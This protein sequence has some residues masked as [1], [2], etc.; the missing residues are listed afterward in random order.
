MQPRIQ[1]Q[2]VEPLVDC[3]RYP[4]KR[5]VGERIEVY[6]TVFKDGHDTLAGAIRVWEPGQRRPREEPL[7]PLGN[8]RW[9][10][11]FVADKPGRWTYAVVAWTDRIATWQ[12]ELRRKVEAGQEDLNG[13][14]SEGAVL[15]GRDELTVEQGLAAEAGDRHGEA[16]SGPLVVD[17]D[18]ELGRFGAWYELF[19]RSWGGFR[20]VAELL[21]ELARLGFDVVYLPPVHPI[22]HTNRKGRNNSLLATE[23]DP[24]RR[25]RSAPSSAGTT[26]S[27]PTSGAGTTSTRW[28]RR[29]GT[30]ASRSRSTSR[31]S[32][33]RTTRG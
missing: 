10:G 19:P 1:I 17:V 32:A 15:L 7:L 22:G 13:E 20:G 6:A 31:S 24:A 5:T 27:P 14:L 28:S 9:G 25:G 30:R 29:R 33:R 26:R 12:D 11:A 3:G 16:K 4:I 18:R 2:A 8:D 23:D 21:P